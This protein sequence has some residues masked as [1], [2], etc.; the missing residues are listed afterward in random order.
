MAR[1]WAMQW[2]WQLV[3]AAARENRILLS[4]SV[5]VTWR[6]AA[7]RHNRRIAPDGLQQLGSRRHAQRRQI[8]C[9]EGD[10][11]GAAGAGAYGGV[12][13]ARVVLPADEHVRLPVA[14]LLDD[15]GSNQVVNTG[16]GRFKC[17]TGAETQCLNKVSVYVCVCVW[18]GGGGVTFTFK[19]LHVLG[20]V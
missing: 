16:G 12:A 13:S 10:G 7:R 18:G 6:Q 14:Q 4:L 17:S 20:I 8:E 19:T 5:R 3:P 15:N 11:G 2:L 1:T 9:F